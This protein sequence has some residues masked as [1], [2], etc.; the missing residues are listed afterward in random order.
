MAEEQ[1]GSGR[2]ALGVT[3]FIMQSAPLTD[4]EFSEHFDALVD[5]AKETITA[6]L[7]HDL[8]ATVVLQEGTLRGMV[9]VFKVAGGLVAATIAGTAS[10]QH[11][12]M[13]YP[14]TKAALAEACADMESLGYK[15]CDDFRKRIQ[16][17]PQDLERVKTEPLAPKSIADVLDAVAVIRDEQK[18]GA[19]EIHLRRLRAKLRKNLTK[20]WPQLSEEDQ[21]ILMKEISGFGAGFAAD[22]AAS[23]PKKVQKTPEPT[24]ADLFAGLDEE[25]KAL[26][27]PPIPTEAE[28]AQRP[29][30][31][32]RTIYT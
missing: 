6:V 24:T 31:R 8:A 25:H 3:S 30:R 29:R 4:D 20:L 7:G 32:Q 18:R 10:V 23:R 9:K 12:I 14:A 26:F 5:T 1:R 22:V 11:I 13:N 17:R 16:A 21:H 19:L 15:L 2:T 28:P 27:L